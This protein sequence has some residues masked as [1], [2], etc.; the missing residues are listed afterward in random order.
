MASKENSIQLYKSLMTKFKSGEFLPVYFICGE[1][2]FFIDRLQEAILAAIPPEIKDFN[3]DL[4]YGQDSDIPRIV[5]AAKSY[6]MMA[7]KR[8]VIVREFFNSIKVGEG[9][10]N[11]SLLEPITAYIQ[12]PSD[13]TVLILIDSKK[14][15]ANTKFGKAF[16]ESE[17]AMLCEFDHID[18]TQIPDWIMGWT[19]TEYKKQIQ[20]E[21]ADLLFQIT[22]TSL[23][24]LST[25]I[26]KICTFKK[27]DEPISVADVKSVAGFSRQYTIIELKDAVIRR[28][29]KETTYIAEQML[30]MASADAGEI[31]RSI[32]FFYTVF[33]NIWKYQRMVQKGF[34]P[35]QIDKELGGPYRTKYIAA[36]AKRFKQKEVLLIFEALLDADKA[37]KGFS[38]LDREAIFLMM[39]RRIVTRVA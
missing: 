16:K 34:T 35:A 17:K 29:L 5:N 7:E 14:P 22:G 20:P 30:Q 13:T 31:I 36:E 1:E 19:K 3:L 32:A 2:Q 39:L 24:Q 4:L 37:V 27:T 8:F 26:E 15:A 12:K 11:L 28:D 25:E 38:K 33:A 23:H 21:A 9:R 10:E 18:G 6:P